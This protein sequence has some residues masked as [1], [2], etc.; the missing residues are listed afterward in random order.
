MSQG[1]LR[2]ERQ[3]H[4]TN[5]GNPSY[6]PPRPGIAAPTE[7]RAAGNERTERALTFEQTVL[8]SAIAGLTIFLGLPVGRIRNLSTRTQALLTTGARPA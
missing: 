1:L 6:A 2:V 7:P 5:R 4:L 8:L 3:G